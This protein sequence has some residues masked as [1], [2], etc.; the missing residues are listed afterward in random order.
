AAA[1]ERLEHIAE[2]AETAAEPARGLIAAHVVASALLGIAQHLV[3]V[4]NRF[5]LLGRL[6]RRVHVGVQLAGEFAIRLLDLIVAR[7]ARDA[8]NV[9]VVCHSRL[10]AGSPRWGSVAAVSGA[11]LL[12]E[13]A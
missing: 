8:E 4:R 5:E 9:V 11:R 6:G 13:R 3:R 12:P 1:E 10:S 2:P 7:L